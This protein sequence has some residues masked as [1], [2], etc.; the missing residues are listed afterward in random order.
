[1]VDEYGVLGITECCVQRAYGAWFIVPAEEWF[2][3]AG[4]PWLFGW[5][6]DWS[7]GGGGAWL[8]VPSDEWVRVWGLPWMIGWPDE[9]SH[10]GGTWLVISFDKWFKVGWIL[11]L[12]GWPDE[13]SHGGGGV[14][15]VVPPDNW[16]KDDGMWEI[17]PLVW[18]PPIFGLCTGTFGLCGFPQGPDIHCCN[19]NSDT[20]D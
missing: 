10:G 1:M 17:I 9:W 5:P 8:I 11:W 12:V 6:D 14:W 18:L 2:R 4:L 13:W 16:C 19:M 20:D 15:L 3:V 7:H